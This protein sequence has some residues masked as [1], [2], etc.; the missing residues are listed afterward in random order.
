M[1]F[2]FLAPWQQDA[3]SFESTALVCDNRRSYT[4]LSDD[5][6]ETTPFDG[7]SSNSNGTLAISDEDDDLDAQL[8]TSLR[9]RQQPLSP[10]TTG[11][12]SE[13]IFVPIK[14]H[15]GTRDEDVNHTCNHSRN[16]A[17]V[18]VTANSSDDDDE[19]DSSVRSVRFN[20]MAEVREMSTFDAPEALLARLSYSASQR[21]GRQKSHHKTARTALLFSVLVSVKGL[22]GY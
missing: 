10:E 15:S 8:G 21:I 14:D 20:R 9:N 12:L 1:A 17:E 19:E 6:N 11:R 2:A 22:I 18:S 4:A 5:N 3:H 7:S 16:D 13:S